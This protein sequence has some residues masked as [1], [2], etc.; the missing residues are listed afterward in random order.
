MIIII[1]FIHKK[2][3]AY[4]KNYVPVRDK[5]QCNINNPSKT[6]KEEEGEKKKEKIA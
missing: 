4:T 3:N 2:E 6:R 5:S 1:W